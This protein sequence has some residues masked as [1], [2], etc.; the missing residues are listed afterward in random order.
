MCCL[1][2]PNNIKGKYFRCVRFALLWRMMRYGRRGNLG[3]FGFERKKRHR[4]LKQ[5]ILFVT[6]VIANKTTSYQWHQYWTPLAW[7]YTIYIFILMCFFG[8][9]GVLLL[10]ENCS[11]VLVIRSTTSFMCLTESFALSLFL[12]LID[13]KNKLGVGI[14]I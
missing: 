10:L 5:D 3:S 7:L 11:I 8:R 2:C 12:L 13:K 1:K 9:C 4:K 6:M 14:E